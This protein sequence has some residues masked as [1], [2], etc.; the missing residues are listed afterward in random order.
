MCHTKDVSPDTLLPNRF[1]RTSVTNFRNK[2]GYTK[3]IP[4]VEE[5]PAPA[6]PEETKIKEKLEET[7]VMEEAKKATEKEEQEKD[8]PELI[9]EVCSVLKPFDM[10]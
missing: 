5:P 4:V 10:N 7:R 1:L 8:E 2:T 6:A 3:A 9:L